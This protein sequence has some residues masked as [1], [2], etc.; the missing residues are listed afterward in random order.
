MTIADILNKV[1]DALYTW[2]LI[3]ILAGAGIFLYDQNE[4]CAAA[5]YKGQLQI[6]V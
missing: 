4:V 5:P 3:Y 1:D 2:L 6:H